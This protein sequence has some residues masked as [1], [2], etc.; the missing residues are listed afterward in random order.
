VGN[1][2]TNLV[3]TVV[4]VAVWSLWRGRGQVVVRRVIAGLWVMSGV[5]SV[6][7][8]VH[9]TATANASGIL[10]SACWIVAGLG[11]LRWFMGS[12]R[13][14]YQEEAETV[15]EPERPAVDPST[16]LAGTALDTTD[17]LAPT[18]ACELRSTDARITRL[19]RDDEGHLIV[20]AVARAVTM[21]TLSADGVA[22]ST[23]P[24][25]PVSYR[26]TGR[27]EAAMVL[28]H[29]WWTEDSPLE[30][31]VQIAGPLTHPSSTNVRLGR[32]GDF[33]TGRNI[34]A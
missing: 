28:L 20:D 4:L 31:H 21:T 24:E 8:F 1:F 16:G 12:V 19:A 9:A 18:A 32:D 30:Y 3:G 14:Q 25:L 13:S 2:T 10:T 11:F 6:F 5:S 23:L 22:T 26:F 27:S 7:D 29:D 34:P 15:P 17:V 33:V